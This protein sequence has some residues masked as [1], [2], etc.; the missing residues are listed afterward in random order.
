MGLPRG[1]F[2]DL[3]VKCIEKLCM[4][5]QAGQAFA[6]SGVIDHVQTRAAATYASTIYRYS[7]AAISPSGILLSAGARRGVLAKNT[8]ARGPPCIHR[9]RNLVV[10]LNRYNFPDQTNRRFPVG[11]GRNV[12]G[13]IENGPFGVHI[14]QHS[15]KRAGLICIQPIR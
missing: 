5:Q 9:L 12:V 14:K 11:P 4:Q 8:L 7:P 2:L 3:D 15:P 1:L 10:R 13:L 6:A